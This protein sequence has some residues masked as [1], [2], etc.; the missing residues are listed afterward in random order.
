LT[1][2]VVMLRGINVGG[3]KIVQMEKLRG[4]FEALGFSRVKTYVQSGNVVFDASTASPQILSKKI[5]QKI[6]NDFGFSVPLVLR[7]S[8][9]IRKIV[10]NNPFLKR[11][12]IDQSKLHVTF[13]SE[14]PAK[15]GVGKL[16]SL[17]ANPDQFLVQ[18]REIFLYCPT[19]YGRTKLSNNAIE[20]A[21]S[22]QATTRN[23]NTVSTLEKMASEL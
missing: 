13:L 19:G 10:R 5:N 15:A 17:N 18:G 23:W 16:D 9:E 3:R 6:L 20:K 1:V 11:P 22:V 12:G 21:L 2:Y 4:T 14:L 7:S 8:D